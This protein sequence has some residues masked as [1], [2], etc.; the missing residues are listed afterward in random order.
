MKCRNGFV[1]NSSSSSFIIVGKYMSEADVLAL[2]FIDPQAKI[3]I[4]LYGIEEVLAES[5]NHKIFTDQEIECWGGQYGEPYSVGVSVQDVSYPGD[6]QM[7]PKDF[8]KAIQDAEQK[9]MN[10][11]MTDLQVINDGNY[12]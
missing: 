11:G 8:V 12:N 5:D 4:G 10:L 2:P 1:S 7:T 3:D 6:L 9:L